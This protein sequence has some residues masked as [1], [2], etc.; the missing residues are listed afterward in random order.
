MCTLQGARFAYWIWL[1]RVPLQQWK[2]QRPSWLNSV[3]TASASL[4]MGSNIQQDRSTQINWINW[5]Q[6]FGERTQNDSI[7]ETINCELVGWLP[8]RLNIEVFS[9]FI[10]DSS[11][12]KQNHSINFYTRS[13]GRF[14]TTPDICP[15]SVGFIDCLKDSSRAG[16]Q[17]LKK[18]ASS[19]PLWQFG[20]ISHPRTDSL[21]VLKVHES[22]LTQ[23]SSLTNLG[24]QATFLAT[25]I[26]LFLPGAVKIYYGEE[27]GLPSIKEKEDS[28]FGLV[29]IQRIVRVVNKESILDA[30]GG[31]KQGIHELWRETLLQI[32]DGETSSRA[33][34]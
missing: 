4:N 16:I 32:F 15:G 13:L 25:S 5:R 7:K 22:N 26:Q 6:K 28:Q 2:K 1:F 11:I 20:D 31:D 8:A 33:E 29:S 24:D 9:I 19:L 14:L 3:W 12:D 30:V 10:S 21:W 27:L 18:N 17:Q 34:F 23:L